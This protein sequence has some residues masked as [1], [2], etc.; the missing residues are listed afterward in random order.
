MIFQTQRLI[1]PEGSIYIPNN[2]IIYPDPY[3]QGR[4]SVTRILFLQLF[5][6]PEALADKC[7]FID[8]VEFLP[9]RWTT[10]PELIVNRTDF[11]RF[12]LAL[13]CQCISKYERNKTNTKLMQGTITV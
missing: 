7:N 9:E 8:P 1:P 13:F 10:Q 6:N 5:S 12:S 3:Q 11:F 2:T 4:G